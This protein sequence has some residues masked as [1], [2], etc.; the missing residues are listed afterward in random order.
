MYKLGNILNT[1]HILIHLIFTTTAC[2][3]YYF[4][5]PCLTFEEVSDLPCVTVSGQADMG[6]QAV[7]F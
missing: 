6:T 2:N 1:L 4:C 7:W 3:K 5:H